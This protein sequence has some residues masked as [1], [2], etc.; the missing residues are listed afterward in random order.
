FSERR[1][2]TEKECLA[3]ANNTNDIRKSTKILRGDNNEPS[4]CVTECPQNYTI[5]QEGPLKNLECIRCKGFCPKICNSTEVN[6]IEDAQKLKGC[7]KII[8]PLVIQILSGR[9]V[10]Q[11]LAKNLGSIKEVTGYIIIKRS[12]ALRNLYFLKSLE[13]FGD[14]PLYDGYSLILVDN[15]NL[16]DLFPEEQMKKMKFKSGQV[17]F[18]GNNKLCLYKINH[19]VKHLYLKKDP[20]EQDISR[21]T[22]GDLTSCFEQHLKLSVTNVL[23]DSAL[24]NWTKDTSNTSHQLTYIINYKE[25]NDESD[26]NIDQ[27]QD[28]CSADVWMTTEQP[29]APG[30]HPYQTYALKDLK[31]Y[32]TYAVY[33]QAYVLPTAT[34]S[35]VTNVETF[36]TDPFYP[37]EPLDLEVSSNDPKELTLKWKPPKF[38]NGIVTHYTVTYQKQKFS[39]KSFEQRDYCHDP[40]SSFKKIFLEKKEEA[41]VKHNTTANCCVCPKSKQELEAESRKQEIESYFENYLYGQAYCERYDTLM[42]K[43]SS[44]GSKMDTIQSDISSQGVKDGG[45]SN[46][47]VPLPTNESEEVNLL[48][49]DSLPL[50]QVLVYNATSVVLQDLQHFQEYSIEVQACHD[51]DA[52]KPEGTKLCSDRALTSGRTKPSFIM[53]S[54]PESSV[55]A[56]T[57]VNATV[58]VVI[59]WKPPP[60]PNGLILRYNIFYKRANQ[61][62]LVPQIICVNSRDFKKNSG[63]HLTGLDHGNWTFQINAV[64]L[65]GNGSL[66]PEKYFIVPY[67]PAGERTYSMIIITAVIVTVTVIIAITSILIFARFRY[68]KGVLTVIS[69]NTNYLSSYMMYTMDEWEVDRDKIK[70]I[71]E[72]GQGAFGMVYEGV[73]KGLGDNPDEETK[74]AVKTISETANFT[75]RMEFLKEATTMKTFNCFHVV[76]LLGVVSTGQPALVIMELMALG[77]LKN[78]LREH[79]PDERPGISPPS[80]MDILQMAGEIADGMAYLADKKFVHRDLAA[81]NCMV[82]E[83]KTVK[84]GD[85]GMTRDIYETDY[86][87]KGSKGMFPVRWMAPESLIDGVFTS[88]S[89]VWSYGVVLWEMITLA[90]QPYQGLSNEEVV[91]FIADDNTMDVPDGCPEKI[92]HLMRHCWTRRPKG[93]PTFKDI[94]EYLLPDLNSRFQKMSYFFSNGGTCAPQDSCTVKEACEA[95]AKV[96]INGSHIQNCEEVMAAKLSLANQDTDDQFNCCPNSKGGSCSLCGKDDG[97]TDHEQYVNKVRDSRRYV[98]IPEGQVQLPFARDDQNVDHVFWHAD[99]SYPCGFSTDDDGSNQPC[100]LYD[101]Q[102][103]QASPSSQLPL[104]SSWP[105]CVVPNSEVLVQDARLNNQ[106]WEMLHRQA[107]DGSSGLDLSEYIGY[108]PLIVTKNEPHTLLQHNGQINLATVDPLT[109]DPFDDNSFWQSADQFSAKPKLS[110]VVIPPKLPALNQAPDS[111]PLHKEGSESFSISTNGLFDIDSQDP[112]QPVSLAVTCKANSVQE[113]TSLPQQNSTPC[114]ETSASDDNQDIVVTDIQSFSHTFSNGHLPL[115]KL[116]HRTAPC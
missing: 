44:S 18:H 45:P 70:L 40:N 37:S 42:Y 65:A 97:D 31:A 5:Q 93:R 27:G 38:P 34:H 21:A 54:I 111:A 52:T 76:K 47:P 116:R 101:F 49:N 48:H 20:T 2:L 88:M 84:I 30:S 43:T 109:S 106:D 25:F 107:C 23:H 11:E 24:L 56:K 83:D 8:G 92:A 78:Y 71:R 35:A 72:L 7:S 96:D 12:Y 55:I 90:A 29:S 82:A 98:N 80:F 32:T 13:I 66:T 113:E 86:Y 41:E 74:V 100:R 67:F 85:F 6:S 51:A 58:D 102:L 4:L 61:E 103:D 105:D 9:S 63:Y 75:E 22:N 68:R 50:K 60:E 114:I 104:A 112:F 39:T 57:V 33:I 46:S 26:I 99:N 19:F 1:C 108:Q 81:R 115:S 15:S 14:S 73:A 36:I 87:R 110:S 79:R 3:L 64:S 95:V 89:D 62:N 91:K 94:I 59:S 10:A 69:P 77:D 28:A 16:Q 53:D 17:F